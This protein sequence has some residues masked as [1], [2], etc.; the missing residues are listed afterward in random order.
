MY[1]VYLIV[2]VVLKE[3]NEAFGYNKVALAK[4]VYYADD[5]VFD[6]RAWCCVNKA[7]DHQIDGNESIIR[8]IQALLERCCNMAHVWVKLTQQTKLF[9][10]LGPLSIAIL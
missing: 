1:S 5:L 3:P 2:V 9:E 4:V 10:I 6:E 7:S 8:L